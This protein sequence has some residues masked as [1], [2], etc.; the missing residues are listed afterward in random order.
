VTPTIEGRIHRFVE[1]GLYDGLFLM[2]DLETGTFWDHL[3]GEAVY[4]PLVGTNLAVASLTQTTAAQA[5]EIDPEARVALSSR[6]LRRDTDMT[7]PSL[8]ATA[9]GWLSGL[10]GS[11]VERE[12]DRRPTMDLGIGIWEGERARYYPYDI[13][14]NRDRAIVDTF[15]GRKVLVFLDP[16]TFVLSAIH[17]EGDDPE[18]Y[19]DVLRLSDGTYVS[20]GLLHGPD[21]KRI[22]TPR[23]LQVFTRWY[24]F[25]LTF[26]G[27][28]IYGE[29]R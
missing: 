27:P 19:E 20:N 24:G 1:H 2:R 21:G 11:T 18:W 15:A 4:G 13:V 14:V 6:R 23:P 25:S 10:F 29:E 16:R 17:V 5:L 26:P 8:L 12:D 22:D 9:G 3:T 7:A 28:D